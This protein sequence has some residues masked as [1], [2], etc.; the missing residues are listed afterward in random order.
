MTT[1]NY[2]N[3]DMTTANYLN[4]DMT[5]ANYDYCKLFK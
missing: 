1:A 4:N 5:T 3:N 2:L